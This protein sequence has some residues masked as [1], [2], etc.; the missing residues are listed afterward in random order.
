MRAKRQD[1]WV[2]LASTRIARRA[3]RAV[4]GVDFQDTGC[5]LR[6]FRRTALDGVLPFNGWHRF[7]PVLA[8]G[9]GATV[10]EVPVNH[11]PRVAGVSKYGI[12]NRLWRGLYDL[13]GVRWWLKKRLRAVSFTEVTLQG[14]R[15]GVG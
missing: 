8:H 1:N 3:R 10:K 6:A 11:R 13:F 2:R 12:W 5:F 9:C 7:L 15:Q 14:P 4:L